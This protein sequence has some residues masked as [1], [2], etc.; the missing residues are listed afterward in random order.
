[1]Q[2]GI[3]FLAKSGEYCRAFALPGEASSGLACRHDQEWRIQ[4]LVRDGG[5]AAG[6]AGYRTAGSSMTP[7]MLKLVEERIAGDA[8]DQSGERAARQRGWTAAD[9]DRPRS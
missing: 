3:S 9:R 2:I 6:A 8:L 7:M 1:V 5:G 4:G